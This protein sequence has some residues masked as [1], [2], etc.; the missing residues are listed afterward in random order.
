[1]DL[2]RARSEL[3]R[4]GAERSFIGVWQ[5]GRWLA[6]V[7]DVNESFE[8]ASVSKQFTAV[9]ILRLIDSGELSWSTD[10]ARFDDKFPVAWKSI[11]IDDLLN[12]TSGLPDYLHGNVRLDRPTTAE[13][14][15]HRIAAR[16]LEFAPG[17]G[18]QYSNSGYMA[19]GY[20]LEKVTGLGL[21]AAMYKLVFGPLAVKGVSLVGGT[22][23]EHE[24]WRQMG[25]GM[26]Q[27]PASA[28]VDWLV[29]LKGAFVGDETKARAWRR[30]PLSPP[31]G[32]SCGW[33]IE[34]EG[35]T[36][37][38]SHAGETEGAYAWVVE[39]LARNRIE[40]LFS[41][42]FGDTELATD[43]IETALTRIEP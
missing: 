6:S 9:A 14:C 41:A 18:W 23:D 39:D 32:Y 29:A 33:F 24:S 26:L 19:L 28:L 13:E 40:V 15:L 27:G 31:P 3:E 34:S 21:A 7:G 11:T 1:M 2:L 17:E 20:V 35:L 36:P 43:E 12:H 42:G 30:Q 16:E 5:E 38:L 10:L 25:D 22:P 37:R 4:Q 8:W